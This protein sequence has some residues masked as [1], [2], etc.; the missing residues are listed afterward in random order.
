MRSHCWFYSSHFPRFLFRTS[1]SLFFSLSLSNFLL[2]CLHYH[3]HLLNTNV[4][5]IRLSAFHI[6]TAHRHAYKDEEE[7]RKKKKETQ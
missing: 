1:P 3:K 6:Q 4:L 5:V 2:I 7:R